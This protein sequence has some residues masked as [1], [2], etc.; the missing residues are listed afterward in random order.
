MKFFGL[1]NLVEALLH[2]S[3]SSFEANVHPGFLVQ[4]VRNRSTEFQVPTKLER[5]SRFPARYG[6]AD[7][8]NP[9]NA[10]SQPI[11]ARALQI[12]RSVDFLFYNRRHAFLPPSE[13]A[14]TSSSEWMAL[15]FYQSW[16]KRRLPFRNLKTLFLN[17]LICLLL[18]QN[19][20]F[21]VL[22]NYQCL[23]FQPFTGAINFPNFQTST[24]T[25]ARGRAHRLNSSR[26][27]NYRFNRGAIKTRDRVRVLATARC[28]LWG[29]KRTR[30]KKKRKKKKAASGWPAR[31]ERQRERS[32]RDLWLISHEKFHLTSVLMTR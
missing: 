28:N 11:S 31:G 32:R 7:L 30:K 13:L 8:H 24:E 27:I 5:S 16:R 4:V 22:Y 1:G 26:C 17:F 15:F 25:F 12:E 21:I 23:L 3:A 6:F 19:R 14:L 29:I 10:D 2:L 18:L 20:Y 9:L